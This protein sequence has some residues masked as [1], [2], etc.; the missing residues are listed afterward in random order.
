MR[1]LLIIFLFFTSV[2]AKNPTVYA[3]LG[4]VIYNNSDKIAKL[5]QIKEYVRL[6]DKI[7]AY[8]TEVKTL[9]SMG[10]AIEKGNKSIDKKEYLSRLREASKINDFFVRSAEHSFKSSIELQN[11]PLF[12]KIINTGLIDLD[13]YRDEIISYYL[14]HSDEMEENGALKVVLDKYELLKKEKEARNRY[15]RSKDKIQR[16]KIRRIREEYRRKQEALERELQKEVDK[17]IS[18]IIRYQKEELKSN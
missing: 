10:F 7:D 3:T 11:T 12:E 2:F 15:Y 16:E 14:A 1:N 6:D 9:K 5:K 17:K 18:N 13:Q 8:L 4:D